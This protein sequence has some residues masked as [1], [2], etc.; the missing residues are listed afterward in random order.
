MLHLSRDRGGISV[1]SLGRNGDKM[2]N[3]G[4][5]WETPPCSIHTPTQLFSIKGAHRKRLFQ[6][7]DFLDILSDFWCHFS[8][9]PKDWKKSISIEI[10]NL[11]W[12]FQS[13]LK[14]SIP[15]LL[16]SPHK[17]KQGFWWVSLAW[18]F[19][20]RLKISI[21]EG[22]L[23]FFFNLWAL[24]EWCF[25]QGQMLAVWALA[26][27]LPKSD[28]NFAVVFGVDFSSWF[29]PGKKG[30]QKIPQQSFPPGSPWNLFCKSPL[31]FLQ[32]PF[33]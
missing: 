9:G 26:A 30:P 29:L 19:Q 1:G 12:K 3:F 24:R 32:K 16:N 23:E 14:F 33:L 28:L 21:P 10:F 2:A 25:P 7:M 17:K 18:K 4:R 22:D 6:K 20:S 8:G 5:I 31:G 11:D 13:R 27:K 15:D